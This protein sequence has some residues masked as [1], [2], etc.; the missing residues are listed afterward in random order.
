MPPKAKK[1]AAPSK[2][3]TKKNKQP[4]QHNP[5]GR[6]MKVLGANGK[7]RWEWA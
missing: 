6:R 2:G 4:T 3:R 1:D 7:I 5:K